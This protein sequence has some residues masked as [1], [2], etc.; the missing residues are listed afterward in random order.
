MAKLIWANVERSQLKT[1]ALRNFC[2]QLFNVFILKLIFWKVQFL[3]N[4]VW[5]KNAKQRGEICIAQS[6]IILCEVK[7][8]QAIALLDTSNHEVESF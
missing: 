2:G 4:A 3:K 5:I 1:F 7:T 6:N 8:D